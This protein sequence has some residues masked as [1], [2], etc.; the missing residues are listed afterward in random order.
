MAE[1]MQIIV[2]IKT[3]LSFIRRNFII[4]MIIFEYFY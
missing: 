4:L 3:Y 2:E 1:K